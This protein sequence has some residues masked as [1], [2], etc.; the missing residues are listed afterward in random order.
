M[1]P[2]SMT[3]GE[4][5]DDGSGYEWSVQLIDKPGEGQR[6]EIDHPFSMNSPVMVRK[7]ASALAAIADVLERSA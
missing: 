7:I 5:Y 3:F 1:K 6:V 4:E 2:V